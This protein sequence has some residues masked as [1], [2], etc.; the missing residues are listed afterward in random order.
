VRYLIRKILVP[1]DGSDHANRA[2]DFALDLAEKYSAEI[3]LL[4][5]VQPDVAPLI[6]HPVEGVSA[7]P[8]VPMVTH[9]KELKPFH[10]KLLS[11]ALLK[12][13]QAKPDLKIST[14]LLEGRPSDRII[15][16]AKEEGFDIV[17]MGSRGLG[18]LKEFFLGSVSDKVVD[19]ATCPVLIVK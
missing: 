11:E 2:L 16:A 5:V 7:V 1:T 10:E 13:Q 6:L 3:V 19:G 9:L 15:A 12:A 18:G 8:P 14:L 4:N 17:V